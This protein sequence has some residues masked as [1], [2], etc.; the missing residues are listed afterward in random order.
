MSPPI[1]A[2]TGRDGIPDLD[3]YMAF[4]LF[5]L[6]GIVHGIKGRLV[7]RH[8]LLRP[9]RDDGGI[10]RAARRAR[11]GAGGEGRGALN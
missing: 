7:A 5:R 6:A 9:C 11:L 2:R 3:F 1:A 10:A 8:R 4:N